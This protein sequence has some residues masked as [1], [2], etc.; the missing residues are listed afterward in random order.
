MADVNVN[1]RG[2]DDG[3]GSQLD[4]L[5]EK[6]NQLG[7]DMSEL[8]KLSDM[9][10]TQQKLAVD[11][12][13]QDTMRA[14]QS[15]IKEEHSQLRQSNVQEYREAESKYKAGD[16]SK[17]DFDLASDRFKEA[18]KESISTEEQELGQVQKEM[19]VQL[20]LIHREMMDQR[21]ITREKSQRDN[22]EFSGAAAGGVLG[23]LAAENK[24]LKQQQLASE[25]ADEVAEMEERIQSNKERMKS[26]KGGD[27]DGDGGGGMDSQDIT[28]LAQ[29]M[30]S[31]N[32]LSASTK[33]AQMGGDALGMSKGG[34][35]AAG[36]IA[37]VWGTLSQSSQIYEAGS[38]VGAMRGQGYDS[39]N[40]MNLAIG[41]ATK[42]VGGP[43][44]DYGLSPVDLLQLME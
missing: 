41:G 19:T 35:T 27:G 8:N 9:T 12:A 4:S 33:T 7:R 32:L 34:K 42:G 23:G 14:E 43:G 37:A 20:R 21:K 30:A 6:A 36:I 18:Q 2:R 24:R 15:R 1:I 13:G 17:K 31:A 11:K 38:R 5:R 26:M 25:N 44:Y 10:P 3:L 40:Q 16:M 39:R 29:A 28:G 22:K